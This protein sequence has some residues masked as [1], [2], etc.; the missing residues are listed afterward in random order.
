MQ[1]IYETEKNKINE[2]TIAARIEQYMDCEMIEAP[3]KWEIDYIARRG[4]K[5]AAW[6]EIKQRNYTMAEINMFGGYMLSLKKWMFAKTL[7][8][9]TGVKFALAIGA[10]DGIYIGSFDCFYNQNIILGGRKDRNDIEDIEPC[11]LI[12][13][14]KFYKISERINYGQE[15]VAQ[16]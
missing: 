3:R 4:D 2:K 14:T 9:M 11:V 12:P 8:D 16:S 7:F 1:K 5:I 13:T 6:V 10:K 15:R